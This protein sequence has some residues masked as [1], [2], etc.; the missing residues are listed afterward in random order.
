MCN[1]TNGIR[2][3]ALAVSTL[4]A[5]CSASA[6]KLVANTVIDAGLAACLMMHPDDDAP[7]LQEVCKWAPELA[8]VVQEFLK[9]RNKGLAAHDRKLGVVLADAGAPAPVVIKGDAGK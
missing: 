7:S 4:V 8:P 9:A 3:A 1:F 2:V 5:G 6:N